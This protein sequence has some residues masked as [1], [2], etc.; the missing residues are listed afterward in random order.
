MYVAAALH[1]WNSLG[2]AFIF[3]SLFYASF[4]A[5]IFLCLKYL[6]NL[7]LNKIPTEFGTILKKLVLSLLGIAVCLMSFFIKFKT[8]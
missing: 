8:H 1:S 2:F 6:T 4:I 5:N 3:V 7:L